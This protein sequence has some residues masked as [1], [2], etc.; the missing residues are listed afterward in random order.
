MNDQSYSQKPPPFP[1]ISQ[2]HKI[3]AILVVM[4]EM[5]LSNF[6]IPEVRGSDIQDVVALVTQQL[7]EGNAGTVELKLAGAIEAF[8]DMCLRLLELDDLK[9]AVQ[10]FLTFAADLD[11]N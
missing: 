5:G 11:G 9:D 8:N 1:P 2:V 3:V 4:N 6:L 10:P 7:D